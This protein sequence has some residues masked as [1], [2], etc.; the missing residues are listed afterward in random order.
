MRLIEEKNINVFKNKI[1]NTSYKYMIEKKNKD[2]KINSI[3]I[4][5]EN[6][7]TTK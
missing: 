4:I 6:G 5:N 3:K 2:Q 7:V 1:E